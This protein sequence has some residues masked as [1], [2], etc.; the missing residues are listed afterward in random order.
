LIAIAA[1][2]GALALQTPIAQ[3]ASGN[4][5]G[6][7]E[8][9]PPEDGYSG[10]RDLGKAIQAVGSTQANYNG[11]QNNATSTFS[12]QASGTVTA[13]VNA[14]STVDIGAIVADASATLGVSLSVSMTASL[15]NS[16]TVTVGPGKTAYATYG[17]WRK[18]TVGTYWKT[19]A[20]C[21]TQKVT[22]V[23]AWSPWYVGWNTW[24][25]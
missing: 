7:T 13:T 17:V 21:T 18:G 20:N 22:N 16:T 2:T 11:T 23:T 1:V 25:N 24:S 4:A 10:I 14:S 6:S 5:P 12:A 15:G 3:A 8:S 9:C 19:L